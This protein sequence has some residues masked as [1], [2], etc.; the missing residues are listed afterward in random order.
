MGEIAPQLQSPAK[1]DSERSAVQF[2]EGQ[3][4]KIQRRKDHHN[5][6]DMRRNPAESQNKQRARI[7]L[8]EVEEGNQVYFDAKEQELPFYET[9]DR[10]DMW[11][12]E[13]PTTPKDILGESP[14][15]SMDNLDEIKKA[16]SEKGLDDW[17]SHQNI[18]DSA[19]R[20]RQDAMIRQVQTARI[21]NHLYTIIQENPGA[22]SYYLMYVAK[23]SGLENLVSKD[24]YTLFQNATLE[25]EKK[26]K[27]VKQ[28]IQD[29]PD[30]NVLFERCFEKKPLGK[31]EIVPGPMTIYFR[32]FDENDYFTAHEYGRKSK[33]MDEKAIKEHTGGTAI[34]YSGITSLQGCLTV[35]NVSVNG[36]YS[37]GVRIHEEKHQFN[38]LFRPLEYSQSVD[39]VFNY[40]LEYS[41]NPEQ[42][43]QRILYSWMLLQRKVM[44][45]DDQ[46]RGEI[47][48]YLH[49]GMT[50]TDISQIIQNSQVYDYVKGF[51]VNSND[52]VKKLQKDCDGYS[53]RF[54]PNNF[55]PYDGSAETQELLRYAWNI[56]G[57]SQFKPAD[58]EPFIYTVF[59]Q[60]YKKDVKRWVEAIEVMKSKGYTGGILESILYSQPVRKWPSLA[61][62]LPH[63]SELL[64]LG[65]QLPADVWERLDA[66]EFERKVV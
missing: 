60:G 50:L 10:W 54:D 44:G 24:E 29:F 36:G 49:E 48:A 63:T 55:D 25:Y 15:A 64:K 8:Q 17:S 30:P 61:K 62:H 59:Q 52:L 3:K 31:V 18:R 65:K 6:P 16:V 5:T 12:T 34:W 47:L 66:I 53:Q 46:A 45:I 27:A 37:N 11:D 57:M 4:G 26:H 23:K 35:E 28:A 22:S 39:D 58:I 19:E 40:A 13:P 1:K 2:I 14:K 56:S 20:L 41:K 51:N 38:K 33:S 43:R 9:W 42:L 32:C 21:I 7:D